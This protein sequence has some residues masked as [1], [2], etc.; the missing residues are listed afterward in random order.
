MQTIFFKEK[1]N[2]ADV[3]ISLNEKKLFFRKEN[4]WFLALIDTLDFFRKEFSLSNKFFF[5]RKN[6]KTVEVC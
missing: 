1:C 3:K 2:H 5:S 4:K 6:R